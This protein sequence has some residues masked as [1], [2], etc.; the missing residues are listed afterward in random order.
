M[1]CRWFCV[2]MPPLVGLFNMLGVRFAVVLC[3]EYDLFGYGGVGCY[4]CLAF[5]LGF[6]CLGALFTRFGWWVDFN[7][8][9]CVCMVV[10]LLF[11]LWW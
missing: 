1:V 8:A 9:G 4:S 6:N 2:L 3:V 11:G 7:C 5:V 10:M